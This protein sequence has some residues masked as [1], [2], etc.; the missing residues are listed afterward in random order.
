M[1]DVP[2]TNVPEEPPLPMSEGGMKGLEATRVDVGLRELG[3]GW[4]R[5]PALNWPTDPVTVRS[6]NARLP[7]AVHPDKAAAAANKPASAAAFRAL[8]VTRSR[9]QS[10]RT[11]VLNGDDYA[12]LR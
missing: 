11:Q 4:E 7:R 9:I 2:V 5:L 6:P 12:A 10:T 8:P 1:A 3:I